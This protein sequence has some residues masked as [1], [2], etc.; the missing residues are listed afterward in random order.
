MCL[1][2]RIWSGTWLDSTRPNTSQHVLHRVSSHGDLEAP[3]HS[4]KLPR[5]LLRALEK[6]GLGPVVGGASCVCATALAG[7]V[8]VQHV[9]FLRWKGGTCSRQHVCQTNMSTCLTSLRARTGL[10]SRDSR[11]T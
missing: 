11:D 2:G 8:A 10:C 6:P 3:G 9:G 5:Q 1:A 7:P 4:L